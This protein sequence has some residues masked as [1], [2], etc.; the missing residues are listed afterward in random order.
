MSETITTPLMAARDAQRQI[1]YGPAGEGDPAS[2]LEMAGMYHPGDK[3][4]ADNDG[5]AVEELPSKVAHILLD[6]NRAAEEGSD[7]LYWIAPE[8]IPPIASFTAK[9]IV[10]W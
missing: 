4:F 1:L 2:L 6:H 9:V 7:A 10:R 8:H 3:Q 5:P